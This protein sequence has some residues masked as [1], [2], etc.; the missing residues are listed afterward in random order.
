MNKVL[1]QGAWRALVVGLAA[2]V[3]VG[4]AEEI[5]TTPIKVGYQQAFTKLRPRRPVVLTHAGDG[6]NRIFVCTQQGVISFFENR[7]D[8]E[9]LTTFLD[10]ESQVVYSDRK[11]EEGL[12]GLAFHPNYK[13][14]GE[15]FVYYTTTDEPQSRP[16]SCTC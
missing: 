7:A 6:S 1:A 8:A 2:L 5:D 10:I 4:S 11:N 14:N 12:L 15:F 9:E 3:S 16:T 13:D